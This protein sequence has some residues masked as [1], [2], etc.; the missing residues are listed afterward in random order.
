[1]L[2]IPMTNFAEK[3]LAT[4]DECTSV[5][6]HLENGPSLVADVLEQVGDERRD[7]MLRTLGWLAKADLIRIEDLPVWD[8]DS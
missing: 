2:D 7:T 1:M 6:D 3:L 8:R 4:S 5:L